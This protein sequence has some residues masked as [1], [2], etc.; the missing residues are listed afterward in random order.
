MIG[1]SLPVRLDAIA[2]RLLVTP[3]DQR[4]DQRVAA[5]AREVLLDEAE[6]LETLLIVGRA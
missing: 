6:L 2:Q 5:A 3:A 4:V 1:A